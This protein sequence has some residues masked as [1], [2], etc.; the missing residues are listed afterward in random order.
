MAFEWLTDL[1]KKEASDEAKKSSNSTSSS[2]TWQLVTLADGKT[3]VNKVEEP[4]YQDIKWVRDNVT[5][6]VTGLTDSYLKS[7]IDRNALAWLS[8]EDKKATDRDKANFINLVWEIT[9]IENK[10]AN[11]EATSNDLVTYL[12]AQKEYKKYRLPKEDESTRS[13]LFKGF[14]WLSWIWGQAILTL[15]SDKVDE[16]AFNRWKESWTKEI[17]FDDIRSKLWYSWSKRTAV[18]DK[19]M[20][21]YWISKDQGGIKNMTQNEIDAANLNYEINTTNLN[22]VADKR[23]WK[24]SLPDTPWQ[25]KAT[26]DEI[27]WALEAWASTNWFASNMDSLVTAAHESK[28]AGATDLYNY[29]TKKADQ[30]YDLLWEMVINPEYRDNPDWALRWYIE[31]YWVNP[32]AY[33]ARNELD[34]NKIDEKSR[35]IL[36]NAWEIHVSQN[37]WYERWGKYSSDA[38]QSWAIPIDLYSH[39]AVL[40]RDIRYEQDDRSWFSKNIVE[41]SSSLWSNMNELFS[42]VRWLIWAPLNT[43]SDW[44]YAALSAYFAGVENLDYRDINHEVYSS[45]A[46]SWSSFWERKW[47]R[48]ITMSNDL[49]TTY[50]T[51][52]LI[53][54]PVNTVTEAQLLRWVLNV[55]KTAVKWTKSAEKLWEL[56][57]NLE[58]GSK[59]ADTVTKSTI[60]LKNWDKASLLATNIFRWATEEVA[61]SLMLQWLTIHEY[62][63]TDFAFDVAW[64]MF[65]WMLRI[66]KYNNAYWQQLLN[67]SDSLYAHWWLADV[68]WIWAEKAADILNKLDKDQIVRLGRAIKNAMSESFGIGEHTLTKTEGKN[69]LNNLTIEKHKALSKMAD[70]LTAQAD[71]SL[72]IAM[73]NST[74]VNYSKYV[75]K[76][77]DKNWR[78]T[79]EWN[80][81]K[82]MSQKQFE[83][84]KEQARVKYYDE[85]SFDNRRTIS[86]RAKVIWAVRSYVEKNFDKLS[87][88]KKYQKEYNRLKK[89]NSKTADIEL[90]KYILNDVLSS[91]WLNIKDVLWNKRHTFTT[92]K[93]WWLIPWTAFRALDETKDSW[94]FPLRKFNIAINNILAGNAAQWRNYLEAMKWT[95][96]M[97]WS[98]EIFLK[99]K[100]YAGIDDLTE[101]QLYIYAKEFWEAFK[102]KWLDIWRREW[103]PDNS[104]ILFWWSD[105]LHRMSYEEALNSHINDTLVYMWVDLFRAIVDNKELPD[106]VKEAILRNKYEPEA[107]VGNTFLWL[108]STALTKVF[109]NQVERK[110]MMWKK[111]NVWIKNHTRKHTQIHTKKMKDKYVNEVFNKKQDWV[112]KYTYTYKSTDK[113]WVSY[114]D[115]KWAWKKSTVGML[116][117]DKDWNAKFEWKEWQAPKDTQS[118]TLHVEK[119]LWSE[120]TI[121]M[122]DIQSI[123]VLDSLTIRESDIIKWWDKKRVSYLK[124]W[125]NLAAKLRNPKLTF[126]EFEKLVPWYTDR[127]PYSLFKWVMSIPWLM[128]NDRMMILMWSMFN[129]KVAEIWYWLTFDL[130]WWTHVFNVPQYKSTIIDDW[131]RYTH[132]IPGEADFLLGTVPDSWIIHIADNALGERPVQYFYERS[133]KNPRWFDLYSE[134]AWTPKRKIVGHIDYSDQKNLKTDIKVNNKKYNVTGEVTF[135]RTKDPASANKIIQENY[136]QLKRKLEMPETTTYNDVY[137]AVYGSDIPAAERHMLESNKNMTPRRYLENLINEVKETRFWK[138]VRFFWSWQ[139]QAKQITEYKRKIRIAD[140]YVKD[141][142]VTDLSDSQIMWA[143]DELVRR[144]DSNWYFSKWESE[145][146]NVMYKNDVLNDSKRINVLGY[147]MYWILP[148]RLKSKAERLLMNRRDRLL[149][150]LTKDPNILKMSDDAKN[151]LLARLKKAGMSE[152]EL[153]QDIIDHPN[154][155]KKLVKKVRT[156]I[157][158]ELKK[159]E[160]T[161]E[162]SKRLQDLKKQI[163]YMDGILLKKWKITYSAGKSKEIKVILDDIEMK[164][165]D[166]MIIERQRKADEYASVWDT[167]WYNRMQKE[168]EDLELAKNLKEKKMSVEWAWYQNEFTEE[169]LKTIAR[170]RLFWET[171]WFT[172][173]KMTDDELQQRIDMVNVDWVRV[174]TYDSTTWTFNTDMLT[175]AEKR[176]YKRQLSNLAKEFNKLEAEWY[177]SAWVYLSELHMI[178]VNPKYVNHTTVWHEWFHAAVNMFNKERSETYEDVARN[179]YADY[180][181]EI[182]TNAK[183]NWYTEELYFQTTGKDAVTDPD[184][185]ML[186]KTEEWL[187]ERFW[188]Y[189]ND[190]FEAKGVVRRFF[191]NLWRYIKTM[192]SDEQALKLFDDIYNHNVQYT[193]VPLGASEFK[194]QT[195]SIWFTVNSLDAN[196]EV[197][198]WWDDLNGLKKAVSNSLG[199]DISLDNLERFWQAIQYG[200]DLSSAGRY[201]WFTDEYNKLYK[202]YV[203]DEAY[204]RSILDS[205]KE[206][207][208][209][210]YDWSMMNDVLNTPESIDYWF[211]IPWRTRYVWEFKKEFAGWSI[212]VNLKYNY[213]THLADKRVTEA[214]YEMKITLWQWEEEWLL[215]FVTSWAPRRFSNANAFKEVMRNDILK[216]SDPARMR[217]T[218]MT[219]NTRILWD[220]INDLSSEQLDELSEALWNDIRRMKKEIDPDVAKNLTQEEINIMNKAYDIYLYNLAIPHYSM[221]EQWLR[222]DK[223]WGMLAAKP[224]GKDELTKRLFLYKQDKINE[225]FRDMADA[226]RAGKLNRV[227]AHYY[228]PS[229]NE[230]WHASMHISFFDWKNYRNIWVHGTDDWI[231]TA[232]QN[233]P[234]V[235][236]VK[237][238]LQSLQSTIIKSW[239]R[240]P[241]S[242]WVDEFDWM[243]GTKLK[244]YWVSIHDEMMDWFRSKYTVPNGA[245]SLRGNFQLVPVKNWDVTDFFIARATTSSA[246]E[247]NLKGINSSASLTVDNKI[248]DINDRDVYIIAKKDF[249]DNAFKWAKLYSRDAYTP[250]F[251]EMITLKTLDNILADLWDEIKNS[252]WYNASNEELIDAIRNSWIWDKY[253]TDIIDIL[254]PSE[255]RPTMIAKEFRENW[256]TLRYLSDYFLWSWSERTDDIMRYLIAVYQDLNWYP[257]VP[258]NRALAVD[259]IN[260]LTAMFFNKTTHFRG[261]K[262]DEVAREWTTDWEFERLINKYYWDINSF[263]LANRIDLANYT[264]LYDE[265]DIKKIN[266][267]RGKTKAAMQWKA[268]ALKDYSPFAKYIEDKTYE[269]FFNWDWY[270]IL[271]NNWYVDEE[272]A[273]DKYWRNLSDAQKRFVLH[274]RLRDWA[275]D[276]EYE[277]IASEK[278]RDL[279]REE[280]N[281]IDDYIIKFITWGSQFPE[282]NIIQQY[283]DYVNAARDAWYMELRVPK[284]DF[285]DIRLIYFINEYWIPEE[286]D[287]V[288]SLLKKKYPD[289]IVKQVDTFDDIDQWEALHSRLQLRNSNMPLEEMKSDAI[290]L[291]ILSRLTNYSYDEYV[292]ITKRYNALKNRYNIWLSSATPDQLKRLNKAKKW[293]VASKERRSW[294]TEKWKFS[295]SEY[296]ELVREYEDARAALSDKIARRNEIQKSW[297]YEWINKVERALEANEAAKEAY[298][299]ADATKAVVEKPV[300]MAHDII[301]QTKVADKRWPV[302]YIETVYPPMR[303][304]VFHIDKSMLWDPNVSSTVNS[305]TWQ[306]HQRYMN[307]TI[308]FQKE[309]QKIDRKWVNKYDA[310]I[311]DSFRKDM[312]NEIST[313][314][315]VSL[316][317]KDSDTLNDYVFDLKDKFDIIRP[318][319]DNNIVYL[320]RKDIS[321][322]DFGK[323][324]KTAGN[325]SMDI[326]TTLSSCKLKI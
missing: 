80:K 252:K 139:Q 130:N 215:S 276:E 166:S 66:A 133:T 251:L 243:I 52:R 294:L 172:P 271:D 219:I 22:K 61:T 44:S 319:R 103:R 127:V 12:N 109:S 88:K 153:A 296:R 305:M 23:D 152:D 65:S 254:K 201:C 71:R 67:T 97:I 277:R 256:K 112:K 210:I 188:E 73:W 36:T 189:I 121:G 211:R 224:K 113:D 176:Q 290:D 69:I 322:V 140:Q 321:D 239:N 119:S 220:V 26:R 15:A 45:N 149:I 146:A 324:E 101:E 174:I 81:P 221:W 206:I 229:W 167:E 40:A 193:E 145:V 181:K 144:A 313:H 268:R 50:V 115:V 51:T 204:N 194:F 107:R 258:A 6:L 217:T 161:P 156:Y 58:K 75:K 90:K 151:A 182:E 49:A 216:I 79:Y 169:E 47:H 123:K 191:E 16:N 136:G 168:I 175:N 165:I 284:L 39:L 5:W 240:S 74:N 283:K 54:L 72:M 20:E 298:D 57:K 125:N 10:I 207:L 60:K 162:E 264:R 37:W 117:I 94:I 208:E 126:E 263:T 287:E 3:Q 199:N 150:Q 1:F 4:W 213:T 9:D 273:L 245:I 203:L 122:R 116:S 192:F 300:D 232:V 62:E 307:D 148:K 250:R 177:R 242:F 266:D 275:Y 138:T 288:I 235:N 225:L 137:K 59:A 205:G 261:P 30:L 309:N 78:I 98:F 195:S 269:W 212:N 27:L 237:E 93:L 259:H 244:Y 184:G 255:Y 96:G 318:D 198:R 160:L 42:V 118:V 272:K 164:S 282:D 180:Q 2:G 326:N 43:D 267:K 323:A 55:S 248:T 14:V 262:F 299:A 63:P 265:I 38:Y 289:I 315:A 274:D 260:E 124:D 25:R 76:T 82:K 100:W 131:Q 11:W 185:F 253:E 200:T 155:Y 218:S 291:N 91:Y 304:E 310:F 233:N 111:W 83:K 163:Q 301:T 8:K 87:K 31:K 34:P 104:N 316:W 234:D 13:K 141:F 28:R 292:D 280:K 142:P 293:N 279:T 314:Q 128:Y 46:K 303:S 92:R 143:V 186:W 108:S 228:I 56:A 214:K 129:T 68:E 238:N 295:N 179:V 247:S 89:A 286:Q 84:I 202:K 302:K 312:S 246:L 278:W 178:A 114:Y 132:D 270:D 48:A 18:A 147:T 227:S 70:D 135:L 32:M 159:T 297:I 209:Y 86:G 308:D 95:Y 241:L 24:V 285:N 311:L 157:D 197:I 190:K 281:E 320:V 236:F 99:N 106:A 257:W 64:A 223:W 17:D 249:S 306:T 230:N 134:P 317:T 170:S 196:G 102:E 183:V 7:W 110:L 325:I 226:R 158:K 21:S 77:V 231:A 19:I 171:R 85:W 33:D 154:E 35:K 187:A 105:M 41:P 222:V 173:T 120:D 53:D 29:F